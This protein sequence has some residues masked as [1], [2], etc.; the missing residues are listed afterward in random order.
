VRVIA[1]VNLAKGRQVTTEAVILQLEDASD[2]YRVLSWKD[3][4]DG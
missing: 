4:F 1:Q 2:P 3:D